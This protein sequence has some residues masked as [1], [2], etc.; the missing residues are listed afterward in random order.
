MSMVRAMV[1]QAPNVPL[2][3]PSPPPSGGGGDVKNP[4]DGVSPDMSVLG[5]AFNSVWVRVAGAIWGLMLAGAAVYLGASFLN[6]AQAKRMSNSHMMTD[7]AGDVRLRAAAL[8]GLVAL[9]LIVG[10]IITVVG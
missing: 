1:D 9:P 10:A 6:L 4:L 8:A 2:A 3:A 5:D 7:A